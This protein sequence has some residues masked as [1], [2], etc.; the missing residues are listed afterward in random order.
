MRNKLKQLTEALL[1][2]DR[3]LLLSHVDPDGDAVGSLIA[4]HALLERRGKRAVAYDRD[5]V[6]E[7]YRFLRGS[8][9][10]HS[11]LETP[12][13]FDA[14]I[15]VECP[16]V[17]R[18]GENAAALV[19][20]IP[21]WINIDHHRD[22]GNF[23]HLN[24]V[25]PQLSAT[26]E[27]VYEVFQLLQ[28]P[29]DRMTAE[30]LYAAIMTDTGSFRFPNTTPRAHVI[31]AELIGLGIEPHEIYQRIYENLSKPAALINARAHAT[32][33]ILDGYSCVTVTRA[34]LKETGATAEDT[35]E[36][37]NYG[38]NIESIEVAVLLREMEQGIKVSLRSKSRVNVSEIAARFGGGGH[39]RAAGCTI[40]A[41]MEQARR[42][43][44]AEVERALEKSHSASRS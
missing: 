4:L 13:G 20:K 40:Q 43:I 39:I 36:I 41:D 6:P 8:E 2:N 38:R 32:L 12:D 15:F 10:I 37:V 29:L 34:M 25:D 26:G 28:E 17:G 44:F 42:L 21:L 19:E 30:A 9:N 14:A 1:S 11:S 35:H 16:N 33:E 31:S 3:F 27:L 18:A 22:N 24:I 7:I 23:G 5:G